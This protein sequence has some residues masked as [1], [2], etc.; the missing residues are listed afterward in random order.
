MPKPAGVTLNPVSSPEVRG[1][2]S[3]HSRVPG[4]NASV[5]G[6]ST[7]RDVL[8]QANKINGLETLHHSAPILPLINSQ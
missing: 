6:P 8:Q 4:H 5:L 2:I 3:S 7:A 1:R